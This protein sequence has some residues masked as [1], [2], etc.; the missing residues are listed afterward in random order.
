MT[1]GTITIE[2]DRFGISAGEIE[3]AKTSGNDGQLRKAVEKRFGK[4]S[5]PKREGDA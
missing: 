2:G 1:P 4:V 5:P 3:L